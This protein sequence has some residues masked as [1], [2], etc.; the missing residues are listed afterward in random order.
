M[1]AKMSPEFFHKPFTSI[2]PSFSCIE[3][4]PGIIL[5]KSRVYVDSRIL[6]AF[7][8]DSI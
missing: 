8:C 2:S 6:N 1:L 5:V 7:T 3:L 4:I